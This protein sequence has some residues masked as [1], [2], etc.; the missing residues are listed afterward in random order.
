MIAAPR[1]L[2]PLLF[3]VPLLSLHAP[4][5]HFRRH[6]PLTLGTPLPGLL[7][8]LH[9]F[10]TV[11]VRCFPS[12]PRSPRPRL[13]QPRE[14]GRPMPHRTARAP[15]PV[16]SSLMTLSRPARRPPQPSAA[17]RP[18][19]RT[20]PRARWAWRTAAARTCTRTP[21]PSARRCATSSR[22]ASTRWCTSWRGAGCATR[23]A[24]SRWGLV[25]HAGFWVHNTRIHTAMVPCGSLR[26]REG[27]G[28]EG[29]AL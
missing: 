21:S 15:K 25:Q 1:G 8:L 19:P 2:R 23:S 10:V 20:P 13:A 24:A 28:T 5:P 6:T 9:V 26:G 17:P 29:A 4:Y 12:Y 27:R 18:T 16:I 14:R 3:T 11:L 7:H 22:A